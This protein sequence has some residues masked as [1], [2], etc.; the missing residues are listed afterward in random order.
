M[1]LNVKYIVDIFFNK[2]CTFA[3]IF[4]DFKPNSSFSPEEIGSA[5]MRFF[6]RL[7]QPSAGCPRLGILCRF[8]WKNS[9]KIFPMP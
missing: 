5:A 6:Y 9:V 3:M 2:I 7:R 8:L 1:V 4:T